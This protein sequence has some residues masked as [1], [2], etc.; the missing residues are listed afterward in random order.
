MSL[1]SKTI[2]DYFVFI[3]LETTGFNPYHDDII[4]IAISDSNGN[5]FETLVK[6]KK[7]LSPKITE[8]TKITDDMLSEKGV[9][10]EDA[11]NGMIEFLVN[12]WHLNRRNR[13]FLIGHN[14]LAFDLP[15]IKQS[16][17][18]YNILQSEVIDEFQ[19]IDTMRMSQYILPERYSHSMFSLSDFL[20]LKIGGAAH[21]AMNDVKMLK[22]IFPQL[23]HLYEKRENKRTITDILTAFS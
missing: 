23:R 19:I 16:L 9:N 10:Q 6:S 18:R 7:P 8:I 1:K 13:L 11:L 12:Q 5:E 15:F 17:K 21:R 2:Q 4:E 22:L 3:D 20:K 14:I